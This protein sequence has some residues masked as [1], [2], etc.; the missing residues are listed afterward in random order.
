MMGLTE[1]Q[2]KELKLVDE[3]EDICVPSGGFV[4]NPDK[5]GRRN[6]RGN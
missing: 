1:E 3:F 2:I 6:G 5:V 4:I